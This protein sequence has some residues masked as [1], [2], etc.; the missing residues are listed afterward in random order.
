MGTMKGFDRLL[1]R[2]NLI[3]K[4][5]PFACVDPSVASAVSG[6]GRSR[7]RARPVDGTCCVESAIEIVAHLIDFFRAGGIGI[8][9][10]SGRRSIV[11][12]VVV[13]L[14]YERDRPRLS[15]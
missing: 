3:A 7:R 5:P 6:S 10:R 4:L 13:P 1:D 8:K 14:G 12:Q 11:E 15:D 2:A 9:D